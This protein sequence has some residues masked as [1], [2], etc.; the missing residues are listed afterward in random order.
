LVIG[1]LG[2]VLVLFLRPRLPE[3][4]R[5]L[6]S[7]GRV[8]E[9]YAAVRNLACGAAPMFT[10]VVVALGIT[11]AVIKAMGPRTSGRNLEDINRS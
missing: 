4:P 9:A 3:S 1:A 5:W 2:A 6:A 10:V 8:E 7:V 11:I